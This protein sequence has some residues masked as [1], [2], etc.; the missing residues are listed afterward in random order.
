MNWTFCKFYFLQF[1]FNIYGCRQFNQIFSKFCACKNSHFNRSPVWLNHLFYENSKERDRTIPLQPWFVIVRKLQG[2]LKASC[3]Y[4][5]ENVFKA[6]CKSEPAAR[7]VLQVVKSIFPVFIR[8]NW[9]F[10]L[11]VICTLTH[12]VDIISNKHSSRFK[13]RETFNSLLKQT[14]LYFLMSK[15]FFM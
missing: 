14:E 8:N 4:V 5:S 6:L 2:K 11:T 9:A 1:L 3:A 13:K 12:A 10:C 7:L 15:L